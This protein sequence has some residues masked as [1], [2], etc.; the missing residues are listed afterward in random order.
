M[1]HRFE[2]LARFLQ[3][4]HW[5][6]THRD[7]QVLEQPDG[8]AYP[9]ISSDHTPNIDITYALSVLLNLAR[10]TSIRAFPAFA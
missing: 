1:Q 2:D 10:L 4:Q 9:L 6:D 5:P 7:R 3:L 8:H